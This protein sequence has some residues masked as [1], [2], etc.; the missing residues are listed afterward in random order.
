MMKKNQLPTR[1]KPWG[2]SKT[3]GGTVSKL[4]KKSPVKYVEFNITGRCQA[5][6]ITCPTP[7]IYPDEKISKTT[8][9]LI[10]EFELFQRYFKTLKKL[11]MEFVTI[12][13]RE[14]A[15]WDQEA[16]PP[17]KFL[18]NMISW[19]A[20]DL[21]VRVCLAASGIT[22]EESV[23]KVLF[24][25]QGVL[26]MKDWGSRPA[27]EKL[28][29]NQEA[30]GK[31]RKSWNLVKKLSRR[32]KKTRVVAE[33]LYTGINRADLPA[34]WKGCLKNGFLP[35]V[36]VPVIK[37]SCAKNYKQL[38][39]LPEEYVRDIY[40]LSLLNLSLKYGLSKKQARQSDIWQ[41]PY[42]SVFPSPCDKLT[43]AKGVFLE[44]DGNLSACCGV[45]KRLGNINDQDIRRKLKNNF[46]LKRIRLAY[47]HLKGACGACDYSRKFQLCYGCR[48]NGYTYPDSHQGVFAH[49]PMC[50][51]K[52]AHGLAVKGSLKK[53]MSKQ[54]IQKILEYFKD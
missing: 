27:V 17:N 39:I 53:F 41:P 51:G 15:L 14:P 26:F 37:G 8:D 33:F 40:E 35:F 13:G 12:Y 54:H 2:I 20:Q 10:R 5:G 22:L 47:E 4:S 21:G 43:Y 30:Y 18:K 34:F 49:D 50:F 28:I 42:G 31:I 36:E 44:R 19:L 16:A 29:R 9:D 24:D 7:R 52:I 6:C 32:Y 11:G 48:G 46:L 23:L 3:A 25:N 1:F 45:D 38:R